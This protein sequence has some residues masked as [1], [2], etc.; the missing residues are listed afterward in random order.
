MFGDASH[1][2]FEIALALAVCLS[3]GFTLFLLTLP[4][5]YDPYK[6]RAP[7]NSAEGEDDGKQSDAEGKVPGKSL[8]GAGKT[9]QIVVLGDIG[10]S[11]R[12][13]YHAISIAKHGGKVFLIG[14]NESEIHPDILSNPH[15]KIVPLSPAPAIL[16]SSS[17][18]LFPILAPLKVIWQTSNLYYAL[19]YRTEPGRWMLVQNPPSIPTLAIATIVSFIR[20]T[21]LVI[22][23]HNFGYSILGLKLGP[24]H[25]LV[26]ISALYEKLFSRFA[27]HHITVTNAMARVLKNDYGA[28]AVTLHDRPASLFQPI[29]SQARTSFLT[30]LP[31]T[32]SYA[33][34]LTSDSTSTPWRLLVS[35]TSWTADEDFSLLLDALC[36]YSAQATSKPNLPKILAIITGKGPQKEH[37]LS[38]IASLNQEGKLKNVVISTA[39]LTPEDYALLLASADLGVSLHTSSS[40]VDL[41]MKV[42]D[43]FG[44]GLPVVGW[45]KFEAWPELVK[46]DVNGKGF[47][48]SD[49]LWQLLV[50]LFEDR[51]GL[52]ATL[53]EGAL[54][55]S[56]YRWDGEWDS[57]GGK[58]FQLL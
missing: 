16:R 32:S 22:D 23:W 13:Q 21:N 8:W 17:K 35:S 26:K 44:A 10:R 11:P 30:R 31:E 48:S 29:S 27:S 37:Y 43:M 7:G 49:K 57:V 54:K 41:P 18:I 19:C 45:G 50:N 4:S 53:K 55:E 2:V 39:W 1:H 46:E 33:Q 51:D 52:L 6:N 36:A 25:P 40:G 38:R 58:L 28:Q 24:R 9:F 12:M 47:G 3:I 34:D 20:N 14:Y 15:V 5:R 56:E 42:V